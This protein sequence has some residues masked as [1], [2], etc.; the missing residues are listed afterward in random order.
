MVEPDLFEPVGRVYSSILGQRLTRWVDI[1]VEVDA[2]GGA[3]GTHDANDLT[4]LY[5]V[6]LGDIHRR[7]VVVGNSRLVWETQ[8]NAITESS[9]LRRYILDGAVCHCVEFT[10]TTVVNTVVHLAHTGDGV[11][12]VSIWRSHGDGS[13]SHPVV[14]TTAAAIRTAVIS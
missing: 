5:L 6:P 1:E 8:N 11:D 4:A 7:Q 2:C 14:L 12:A 10:A 3:S 9:R 13:V